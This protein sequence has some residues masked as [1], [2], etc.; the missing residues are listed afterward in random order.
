VGE[1]IFSREGAK[2]SIFIGFAHLKER[3]IVTIMLQLLQCCS[4]LKAIS[5]P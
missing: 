5:I 4:S 3:E 1:K 2:I